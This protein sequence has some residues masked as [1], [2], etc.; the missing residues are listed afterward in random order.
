MIETLREPFL[1]VGRIL[2][3]VLFVLSGFGKLT[4]YDATAAYMTSHGMGFVPV[5][6]PLSIVVE[7][8]GGLLIVLGLFTRPVA[9]IMFLFV[10]PVTFV[11]HT[12]GDAASQ[13]QLL[14]NVSIMGALLLLTA[15]GPGRYS[16]DA[17]RT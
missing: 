2:L 5:L 1:L 10:I 17:R 13:I 9:L 7:L 11:F 16:L 12:G 8:G 3:V 4:G 6:L 15:A 14:K